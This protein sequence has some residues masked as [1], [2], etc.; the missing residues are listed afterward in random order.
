MLFDKVPFRAKHLKMYTFCS[1]KGP[2]WFAIMFK[3]GLS[4]YVTK[5]RAQLQT[6]HEVRTFFFVLQR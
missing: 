6:L 4:C 3:L 5:Q 2:S 1:E